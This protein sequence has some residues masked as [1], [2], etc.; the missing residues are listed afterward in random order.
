MGSGGF[1]RT[2]PLPLVLHG[3]WELE[4]RRLPAGGEVQ[5]LGV[6]PDRAPD[7]APG[8]LATREARDRISPSPLTPSIRRGS[9][10]ASAA[11]ASR[12]DQNVGRRQRRRRG[13]SRR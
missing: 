10:S 8:G 11:S 12:G 9:A 13:R 7:L 3:V 2:L 1:Q 4:A 6:E 5:A